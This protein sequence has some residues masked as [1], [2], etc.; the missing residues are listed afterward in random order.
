MSEKTPVTLIFGITQEA[1][2]EHNKARPDSRK[3][4]EVTVYAYEKDNNLK[5]LLQKHRPGVLVSIG[6]TPEK[7]PFLGGLSAQYRFRWINISKIDELTEGNLYTCW[8]NY[9]FSHQVKTLTDPEYKKNNILISVYTTSYKSKHRILRPERSLYKQTY[10]NWEWVI[11]DDSDEEENWELL[12]KIQQKDERIRIYKSNKNSGV[13]GEVKHQ[14]AGLC[15]GDLLVEIDHDDD[16]HPELFQWLIDA[17]REFPKAG[18]F[19]TDC[20]ELYETGHPCGYPGEWG[21][22]YAHHFGEIIDNPV[23][24][25]KNWQ[26]SERSP[27]INAQTIRHIIGVPNHVRAWTREAYHSLG[28]YNAY[29]PIVDDYELLIRTFLK[30]DMVHIPKTGYYQYR[31]T[32]NSNF[33]VIR[34]AEIQK[35]ADGVS[36]YYK[37]HYQKRIEEL[38]EK[39]YNEYLPIDKINGK[40]YCP[41]IQDHTWHEESYC[42]YPKPSKDSI[43][44]IM[45]T[46]AP[47]NNLLKNIERIYDQT[48]QNWEIFVITEGE[49]PIPSNCEL[50]RLMDDLLKNVAGGKNARK[51]NRLNKKV[52]NDNRHRLLWWSLE[53]NKDDNSES[54]LNHVLRW[55]VRT[56]WVTYLPDKSDISISD[57]YL[58]KFIKKES[59]ATII[60]NLKEIEEDGL[61]PESG[62]LPEWGYFHTM[63]LL[64]KKRVNYW[65]DLDKELVKASVE[66]TQALET[67]ESKT[68]RKSRVKIV[69]MD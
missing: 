37:P 64:N 68:D 50:G 60:D 57:D 36:T 11:F 29:L 66:K 21:F 39:I 28:G 49:K 32:G 17:R 35:H 67:K 26:W 52:Q 10:D 5:Q 38:H 9:I 14:A 40:T 30:Y 3:L 46:M 61:S 62:A 24:G 12:K 18:F 45:Y 44:I 23:T 16:L 42:L 2:D 54:C 25:G 59:E 56:N 1:Y 19:F 55:Y 63:D 31:N 22:G 69:A 65:H 53:K 51:K 13:I 48:H 15:R 6:W 20:C 34:N 58:E 7:F 41:S 33:T 27:D 8:Y 43:T 4:K 47:Y